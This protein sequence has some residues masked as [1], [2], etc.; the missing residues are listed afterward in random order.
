MLTPVIKELP[1][2]RIM[3]AAAERSFEFADIMIAERGKPTMED[4]MRDR[5]SE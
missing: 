3:R 4:L 5:E 2:L 1:H